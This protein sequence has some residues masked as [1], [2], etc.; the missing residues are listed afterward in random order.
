MSPDPERF[1]ELLV[2]GM[3][4]AIVYADADGVI[5]YWNRGAARI[6]GF[7][8]AEALG[9]SLDLI[10][11]GGLRERHWHGYRETMR[12]GQSRYGEGQLLSVPAVRKDGARI[13]VEFTIVPFADATGSMIGIAAIMRDITARFEEMRALRKELAATRTAP[14]ADGGKSAV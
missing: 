10:I 12:T 8:E 4:E 3:S 7:T 2:A 6:F 14:V 5:R 13:S 1:P 11:P 9:Q